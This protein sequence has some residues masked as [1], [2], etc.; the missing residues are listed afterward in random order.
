MWD[1]LTKNFG[2][3]STEGGIFGGK[4]VATLECATFKSAKWYTYK[5]SF[6]D[7]ITL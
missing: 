7:F 6:M 1:F 4:L 3:F 2:I 5:Y